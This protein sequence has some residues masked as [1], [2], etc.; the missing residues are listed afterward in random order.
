M[1]LI[2]SGARPTSCSC[3]L[4]LLC[5]K[6]GCTDSG[7]DAYR[8]S[9]TTI[10]VFSGSKPGRNMTSECFAANRFPALYGVSLVLIWQEN[11]PQHRKEGIDVR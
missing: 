2:L 8:I 3:F 10:L 7:I 11:A 6:R 9:S 5:Q 4:K 1:N